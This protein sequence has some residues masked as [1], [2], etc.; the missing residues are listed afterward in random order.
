MLV[1]DVAV[2][3]HIQDCRVIHSCR[4]I[5]SSSVMTSLLIFPLV[6]INR[7]V[8]GALFRALMTFS[9]P[10]AVADSATS[11]P[12]FALHSRDVRRWLMTAVLDLSVLFTFNGS[13]QLRNDRL[14]SSDV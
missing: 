12:S 2:M 5:R 4:R 6:T 9:A 13:R 14:L 3:K 10:M 11:L 8:S 1:V 7:N